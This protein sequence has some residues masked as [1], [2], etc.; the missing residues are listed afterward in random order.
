MRQLKLPVLLVIL[1]FLLDSAHA[2]PHSFRYFSPSFAREPEIALPD[3]EDWQPQDMLSDLLLRIPAPRAPR[4]L[5][6]LNSHHIAKRKCNAAT[7]VTQ[8]LAD[9]M[10]RSS[11]TIGV[12]GLLEPTNVGSSTYGK[13]SV[14]TVRFPD[15]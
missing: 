2:A 10:G 8:R 6:A 13:R 11:N 14:L 9:F 4:G 7:C 1:P 15:F 5:T 12:T 3:A